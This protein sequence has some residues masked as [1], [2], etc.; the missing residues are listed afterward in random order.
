MTNRN[1]LWSPRRPQKPDTDPLYIQ[2]VK[3]IQRDKRSRWSKANESGLSETT[4]R[5]WENGKVRHPQ[6][7]SLQLAARMLGKQIKLVD[8]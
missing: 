8:K 4:L 5:N 1:R 2:I 6:G 3:L 7:V